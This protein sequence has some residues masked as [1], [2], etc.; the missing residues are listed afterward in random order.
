[1]WYKK[2]EMIKRKDRSYNVG[3]DEQKICSKP[4]GHVF[5]LKKK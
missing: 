2:N 1:M 5:L 4:L 3:S